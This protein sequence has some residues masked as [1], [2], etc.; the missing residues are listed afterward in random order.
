MSVIVYR[1]VS[2]DVTRMTAEHEG[3]S[4][5]EQKVKLLKRNEFSCFISK[6]NNCDQH[7]GLLELLAMPICD[8]RAEG[9]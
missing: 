6:N 2:Y 4:V 1:E 8:E 3:K 7:R 5:R 9:A